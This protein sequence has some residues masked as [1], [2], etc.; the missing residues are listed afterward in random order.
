M[1]L[2]PSETELVAP[3]ISVGGESSVFSDLAATLAEVRK[4]KGVIGYIL[5]SNTA[6]VIDLVPK[7]SV[8]DYALLSSQIST[9]GRSLGK[10]IQP[11]RRRKRHSRRLLC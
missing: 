4:L 8:T 6:A 2:K 7:E 10:T 11:N 1:K 9:S 3:V 5:R